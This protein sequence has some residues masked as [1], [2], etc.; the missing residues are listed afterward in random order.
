MKIK[1]FD[2]SKFTGNSRFGDNGMV[3]TYGTDLARVLRRLK[4]KPKT[5]WTIIDGSDDDNIYI[6][7]G[8]HLVNRVNYFISNEEWITGDEEFIW[9]NSE[10]F[11]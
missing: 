8:Y 1:E 11:E 10:E 3:E 7:A 5:I 4:T 9:F 6:V 2:D